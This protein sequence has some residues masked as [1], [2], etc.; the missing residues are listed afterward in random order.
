MKNSIITILLLLAGLSAGAQNKVLSLDECKRIALDNSTEV[1]SADLD[2][3]AAKAKKAEVITNFF[4]NV[5]FSGWA[6]KS[7][8]YL[9]QVE[10]AALFGYSEFGYNIQALW[11]E[12]YAE[13]GATSKDIKMLDFGRHYG[14]TAIQPIFLGGRI[15]HGTQYAQLGV[16][17]AELKG[18]IAK[19]GKLE[20][21]EANYFKVTALQEKAKTLETLQ[22]LVDS[23]EAV[24]G[25]ALE[26]GVILKA[27]HMLL[28][29]KKQE[30]QNGKMKL[31]TGL[32]LL[33]MNLLSSIGMEYSIL[34][35]DQYEFP[36]ASIDDIPSPDKVY[37]DE[38]Q[39][40]ECT[41]E[42]RLLEMQVQAKKYDK[43][44]TMGAALP[45]IGIGATYG[46][47]MYSTRR[48]WQDNATVF[49]ALRIPITDW[50]KT[51]F[52]LRQN[53][54]AIDKAVYERDHLND[55][56]VLQQRKFYLELT[57]AWDELELAR[58]QKEYAEY[59]YEQALVSFDAGFTTVTDLLQVYSN[60]AT[61]QENYCNAIADYLSALQV[62]KGRLPQ[63]E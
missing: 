39:V 28:Q 35:L 45:Q 24:A 55:M 2:I 5:S 48:G 4:P 19:R 13:L 53:Q 11:E 58:S 27:D 60:L 23:L 15:I 10:P 14:F 3:I 29:T 54:V 21:V 18:E 26:E 34:D 6:F 46:G 63:A 41:Q 38:Y 32:R 37:M 61:N 59:L 52:K 12:S 44:L 40:A 1:K 56:L 7:S 33:K 20:E 22:T 47:S 42:H 49:I 25:I 50:A 36:A 43:L 8:D 30:L 17:A 62:Y 16:E 51:S 57:S 9:I 31:R